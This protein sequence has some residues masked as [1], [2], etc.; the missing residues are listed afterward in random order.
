MR[1]GPYR[2]AAL[3]ALLLLGSTTASPA[4]PRDAYRLDWS[5]CGGFTAADAAA[6][7]G[8]PAAGVTAKVQRSHE[9]L[10]LCSF[11]GSDG[12]AVS[13]S[14]AIAE[15]AE[16]AAR[17]LESYRANLTIAAASP[18][19]RATVPD[20]ACSPVAGLGDEAFWT[21]VNGTLTVRRKNVSLQV[22]LPPERPA[23]V[24]VAEAFLRRLGP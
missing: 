13:F 4:A 18:A 11:A 17:G 12:R 14:I 9:A 10:W 19:V 7:L 23:Q 15:S 21:G 6:I 24:K 2:P 20:G 3:A 1:F 16:E 8:V 22:S 5:R